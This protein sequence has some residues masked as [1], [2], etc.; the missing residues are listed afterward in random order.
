MSEELNRRQAAEQ[1]Q[2]RKRKLLDTGQKMAQALG[3]FRTG[4]SGASVDP[5]VLSPIIRFLST[6][7]AIEDIETYLKL[8]PKSHLAAYTRSA[9]P[10]Y[11][12][13]CT[14]VLRRLPSVREACGKDSTPEALA[15]VLAWCRRLM[16][17]AERA[18]GG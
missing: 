1:D 17:A 4:G 5:A 18:R 3:A 12:R 6:R 15:Y 8:L 14:E 13:V 2:E 11:E 9:G 7:P 10:Q 16:G